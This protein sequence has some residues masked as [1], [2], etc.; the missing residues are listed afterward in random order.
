MRVPAKFQ[1]YIWL[2][3][4]IRNAR[5]ISLPELQAKW[6]VSSISE[7]E[8]LARSTFFRHKDAIQE[9]F[10]IDLGCDRKNGYRYYIENEEILQ[11]DSV[12]NWIVSTMSVNDL[13]T[14]N[15]ALQKRILMENVPC[16]KYLET[17]IEAMKRCVNIKV[18]YCKYGNT[19]AKTLTFEPYCI[20]LFRKRWYLLAHFHYQATDTKLEADYYGMFSFDRIS[21]IELTDKQFTINPSFDAQEFFNDY[22]GVVIGDGTQCEKVLLR[23]YGLQQYYWRDLPLHHSQEEVCVCDEYADFQYYLKPT[24]DFIGYILSLG[25]QARVLQ[26]QWLAD[27]MKQKLLETLSRYE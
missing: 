25:N 10:G 21:H 17:V 9:I 23:A 11:Q 12:Q 27:S 16:D 8:E 14:D 20:K 26:P 19:S 24:F 2:V 6:R 18:E 7:G 1:E 5:K 3:N 22:Y 4:T 15:I 13:V